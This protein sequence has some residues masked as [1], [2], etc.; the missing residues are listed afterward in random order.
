MNYALISPMETDQNCYRVAEISI[1]QFPVAPP[2]F[3]LECADDITTANWY[4]P[5]TETFVTLPPI[6]PSAEQ[7]K[8]KA[9]LLLKQTDWVNEPDV[10]NIENT[11]HLLNR[12]DF[13]NYR[14]A[15][16]PYAVNPVAGNIDW[17]ILPTEQW[18]S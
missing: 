4:D 18:S 2:L 11:P 16:R 12:Q 13:L 14:L 1:Q 9:V 8:S 5:A 3:W 7:N 10:Y 17:P 6:A 15:V